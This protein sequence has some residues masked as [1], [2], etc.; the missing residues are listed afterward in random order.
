MRTNTQYGRDQVCA[1][2]RLNNVNGPVAEPD[3]S[4]CA[5]NTDYI[6]VQYDGTQVPKYGYGYW[7]GNGGG[8]W[9]RV[10]ADY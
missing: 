6:S 5:P 9:V 7:S 4:G 10:R 8:I 3:R 1:K 2:A